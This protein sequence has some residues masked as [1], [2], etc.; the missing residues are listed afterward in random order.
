MYVVRYIKDTILFFENL[1]LH[2]SMTHNG[3]V[4]LQQLQ[5]KFLQW[6]L[7]KDVKTGFL[8]QNIYAID[9]FMKSQRNKLCFSLA[10]YDARQYL[11]MNAK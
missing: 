5:L 4:G 10:I 3:Y 11:F 7:N 9:V 6:R 2:I 1:E 8:L